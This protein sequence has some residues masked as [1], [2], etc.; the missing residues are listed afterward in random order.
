MR[1]TL[2]VAV[3]IAAFF[4]GTAGAQPLPITV[5]ADIL[6]YDSAQQVVTAQGHVRMTF[7][8]YRLFAD[9]ARYDLR[10]QIVV[11]T[12]HVRVID[13]QDRELRGSELTFNNRT[14]EGILES[15]Q[16][17]IDRERRVY[18][19]GA[20][21]DFTPDRF[22]TH[23]SF[24]TNCDPRNPLVH[25]TAKRIEIVPNAEIIAYDASVY[26]GSRRLWTVRR[27]VV[28]LRPDEKGTPF[29]GFG[30]GNVD[31]YWVDYR[32]PLRFAENR[33]IST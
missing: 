4:T 29:P 8:R 31:G 1:W 11:A 32:I 17:V 13:P 7:K 26:V 28:S 16:G 30:H 27:Y 9:A 6:T 2:F 5:D 14:E 33:G 18:L 21:L 3:L 12:G 22:V 23:D 20:R 15:S 25:L 19:R 24:V 10:S